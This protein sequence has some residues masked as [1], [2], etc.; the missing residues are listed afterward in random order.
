M[1]EIPDELATGLEEW[2]ARYRLR[3]DFAQG[4]A[5]ALVLIGKYPDAF[6]QFVGMTRENLVKAIDAARGERPWSDQI[7]QK[8]PERE[9]LISCWIMGQFEP[10]QITGTSVLGSGGSKGRGKGGVLS[11]SMLRAMADALDR[12]ERAAS[13]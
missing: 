5:D 3:R 2:R 11:P 6:A 8:F 13:E 1:W 9:P 12:D 10:Q 4:K 7:V